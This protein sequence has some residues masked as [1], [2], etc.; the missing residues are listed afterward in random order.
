MPN[1][2]VF[3]IYYNM[4]RPNNSNR[5]LLSK[6]APAIP[7]RKARLPRAGFCNKLVTLISPQLNISNAYS[8]IEIF[9]FPVLKKQNRAGTWKVRS[10]YFLE[11]HILGGFNGRQKSESC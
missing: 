4:I 11:A 10:M 7:A 9:L 3:H 1:R 5:I 2:N 8:Q 6:H